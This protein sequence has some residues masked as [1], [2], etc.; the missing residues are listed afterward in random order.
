M[1]RTNVD[2]FSTL[3]TSNCLSEAPVDSFLYSPVRHLAF[4]F[5]L[6]VPIELRTIMQKDLSSNVRPVPRALAT[7]M[8]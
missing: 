6:A 8:S 4:F 7:V 1:V 3:L 2:I 5:H